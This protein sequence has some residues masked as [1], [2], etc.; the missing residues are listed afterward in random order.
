MESIKK[1][2]NLYESF[3]KAKKHF[4][5]ATN[6]YTLTEF[7]KIKNELFSLLDKIIISGDNWSFNT[8]EYHKCLICKYAFYTPEKYII[9]YRKIIHELFECDEILNMQK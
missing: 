3:I 2:K 5:A 8:E 6:E 9:K 4:E 7:I 1:I